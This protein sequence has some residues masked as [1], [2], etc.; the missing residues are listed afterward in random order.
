MTTSTTLPD[1]SQA[2]PGVA[3][4]Y[5]YRFALPAKAIAE[6]Q[7]QH[8][9]ACSRL[10]AGQCQ[11]TGMRFDQLQ[12]GE[13]DARLDLLLAPEL[14]HQFGRDGIAAV[15]RAEGKLANANVTGENAGETVN[16]SHHSSA[17]LQAELKRTEARL[18]SATLAKETRI[19]L[20]Q[21]IQ[22]LHRQLNQEAGTRLAANQSL[23][24]T[25][26]N[27]S[28]SSQGVFD[29]NGNVFGTAANAS[30]SSFQSLLSFLLI[31]AGVLLPWMLLAGAVIA[32]WRLKP[33]RR[34]R[35]RAVV[36]QIDE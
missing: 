26:V 32:V 28:Y 30:L 11:V 18:K 9:Q 15:E 4:A 13:V 17:T 31:A 5:N 19:E 7:Q 22:E 20:E 16:Q 29:T 12:E 35:N 8:A 21:R 36:T 27:F 14:A 1:V 6:V 23:A 33:V 25:P 10:G 34:W 24:T 2:A 3:F